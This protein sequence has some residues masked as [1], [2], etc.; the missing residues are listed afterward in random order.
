LLPRTGLAQR[1][2]ITIKTRTLILSLTVAGLAICISLP[3][4]AEEID[5]NNSPPPASRKERLND[6]SSGDR[7]EMH[8]KWGKMSPEERTARR[9][10]MLEHWEK[11]PPEERLE[12]R[13]KMKEHWEK[14]PPEE[15]EARRKEMREH[16]AKMS[17][18]ERDQFKRDLGIQDNK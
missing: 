5:L 1:K 6:K 11:M 12:M 17:P 8:D 10:E 14:M 4:L 13:K 2:E 18:E 7:A 3:A 9:K 15:R 16:W